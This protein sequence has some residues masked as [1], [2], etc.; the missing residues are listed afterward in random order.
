ML[1]SGQAI[2]LVKHACWPCRGEVSIGWSEGSRELLLS[3]VTVP[4]RLDSSALAFVAGAKL[5]RP[6]ELILGRGTAKKDKGESFEDGLSCSQWRE[7]GSHRDRRD[8][9]VMQFRDLL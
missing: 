9:G 4:H 7:D 5:R 6:V 2:F 3:S 1:V 8:H